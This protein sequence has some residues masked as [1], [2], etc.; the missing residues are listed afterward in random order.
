MAA[1]RLLA[2]QIERYSLPTDFGRRYRA[3]IRESTNVS[4]RVGLRCLRLVKA[5][6]EDRIEAAE[7]VDRNKRR[8]QVRADVFVLATGGLE[9]PRLLMASAPDS[10]FGNLGDCLGRYYMCHFECTSGRLIPQGARVVFDFEK[11][12]DGV[13][14]RRQ[15]RFRP[16]VLREQRLLNMAF[17]LHFPSYSDASHGSGVMST[18]FLAKSVLIP[19]YRSI[20]QHGPYNV[21]S[22]TLSHVGNVLRDIPGILRFAG[23]WLFRMKLA[24]RKLPYTLVPNADG[25]F[26]L[27]FNSEQVPLAGNRVSLLADR[28]SDGM[29]RLG[30]HWRLSDI[31]LDSAMRGFVLLRETLNGSGVARLEVDESTSRRATGECTSIGRAPYRNY[32]DGSE[33]PAGSR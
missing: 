29:P 17:R 6:G 23:D 3:Q 22:P 28:D 33:F 12:R 7:V 26:P 5:P 4:A 20:L 13:Y 11:T 8:H 18:I 32:P 31:D 15:L 19:E 24:R 30:I 21:T 14:C 9:A 25:S 16:E 2:G 27:E 1:D 10:G